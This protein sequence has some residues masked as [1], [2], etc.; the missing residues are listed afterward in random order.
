ME[1]LEFWCPIPTFGDTEVHCSTY[2]YLQRDI[3]ITNPE[4][5]NGKSLYPNNILL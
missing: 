1:Q 5:P 3:V 2:N 4:I